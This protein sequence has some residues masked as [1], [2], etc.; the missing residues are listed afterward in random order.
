[1]EIKNLLKLYSFPYNSLYQVG[2]HYLNF[3]HNRV[4]HHNALCDIV[5]ASS[6]QVHSAFC[7]LLLGG[8][9]S[10]AY[11]TKSIGLHPPPSI[12]VRTLFHWHTTHTTFGWDLSLSPNLAKEFRAQGMVFRDLRENLDYAFALGLKGK[13]GIF[14]SFTTKHL[15]DGS[16]AQ[17]L[18]W[19]NFVCI[20]C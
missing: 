8:S 11:F 9:Q 15:L 1:M 6:A 3:G 2:Q 5:S 10:C 13:Y 4:D 14:P 19:S 20:M 16:K 17:F 7:E 12:P 18:K